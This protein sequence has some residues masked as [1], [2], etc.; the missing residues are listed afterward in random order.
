[1]EII[2][3]P[4][5]I[6]ELSH[7][8]LQ[9]ELLE[10]KQKAINELSYENPE[11]LVI[12]D[13]LLKYTIESLMRIFEGKLGQRPLQNKIYNT[14]ELIFDED[15]AYNIN[16]MISGLRRAKKLGFEKIFL[17]KE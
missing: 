3:I 11:N 1:M 10:L 7:G 16:R 17:I 12:V 6:F 13:K 2:K 14:V 5:E 9:K 4:R 8:E 15:G